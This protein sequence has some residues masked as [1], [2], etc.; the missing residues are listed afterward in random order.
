MKS[1]RSHFLPTLAAFAVCLA[2]GLALAHPGGPAL[3]SWSA[4][5]NHP[6]HGLDHM[7][8]MVAVGLWA[9]QQRGRAAWAIPLT[10]LSVMAVGG[11]VGA[12]GL[13][14]PG[15][16]MMIGLSIAVVGACV[17]LRARVNTYA[18]AGVVGLFAFFHGYAHGSEMPDAASLGSYG[19]GFLVATAL[20]HGVGFFVMRLA[21]ALV[22]KS[23]FKASAGVVTVKSLH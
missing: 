1:M 11:V 13:I 3:H 4:G 14:I 16:E 19:L 9:A 18:G 15:A 10:F 21:S 7:A 8:V 2:P 12:T 5:F 6:L 23:A 17:V 22:A 20:L